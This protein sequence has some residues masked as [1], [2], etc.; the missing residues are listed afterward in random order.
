MGITV[1]LGQI[2][3]RFCRLKENVDRHIE[4]MTLARERGAR[5]VIFPE[6]SLTG[7]NLR[8][9]VGEMA[10]GGDSPAIQRLIAASEGICVIAGFVERG[11]KNRLFNAA[12]CGEN[13][14]LVGVHRKVFLPTYGMFE[15]G[16]YFNSG[17][18]LTVLPVSWGKIGIAI[19]EDAWH[20]EF[21]MQYAGFHIDCL[22]IIAAS[23]V[24]GTPHDAGIRNQETNYAINRTHARNL[25]I[26]T[27]FV[28]KVGYEQGIYFWG[29][30]GIFPADGSPPKHASAWNEELFMVE[31]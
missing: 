17:D 31:T 9:A 19:C 11:V 30:S 8:D 27:L 5:V 23:P 10:V 4:K 18:R 2:E 25:G 22:V 26:P 14:A 12:L 28:N 20:P 21:I 24:R 13:F 1:A 16:R 7:Y 6:L 29:G 15:E 3:S